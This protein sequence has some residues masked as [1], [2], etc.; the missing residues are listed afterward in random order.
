MICATLIK[1]LPLV[2]SSIAEHQAG[3][4][5]CEDLR[6][7]IVTRQGGMDNFHIHRDLV[8]FYPKGAKRR[9]WVV[10]T[11]LLPMLLKYFHDSALAGHLG[12]Y[13]SFRKIAVNFWWPKMRT[14]IFSYV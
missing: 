7:K 8:C 12:A 1:S 13:K 2:Y 9:R 10:P 5:F 14:E 4:P 6:Q 3:D 11:I